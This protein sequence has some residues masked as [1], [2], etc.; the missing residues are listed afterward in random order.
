MRKT[1]KLNE[2]EVN[3]AEGSAL[4]RYWKRNGIDDIL[5][6]IRPGQQVSSLIKALAE[7]DQTIEMYHLRGIGYGNWVT[8]E[9]RMNYAIALNFSLHDLQKIL[10]F[11]KNNLGMYGALAVTFGARGIPKALA[12]YEPSTNIINISR[13]SD[14]TDIDKKT[15]FMKTGGMGSFAHEYGHFLDY[16]FGKNKE[17]SSTISLSNGRSTTGIDFKLMYSYSKQPL[18]FA[19]EKVIQNIIFENYELGKLSPYYRLLSNKI[20]KAEDPYF[21]RHNELFARAF[22][23]YIHYYCEK[24][25][26]VNRFLAKFK[27]ESFLYL[28]PKDFARVKPY[29]DDLI[30]LIRTY[31]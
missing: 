5:K 30:K 14:D 24:Y 9:D 23:V 8:A 25:G 29:M 26:I 7:V 18:R 17:Q 20:N 11:R 16:F 13:Y 22:E 15:R 28:Q 4:D 21:F 2:T 6:Q 3:I 27:Y 12:H 19:M 31:L 1:I 10:N